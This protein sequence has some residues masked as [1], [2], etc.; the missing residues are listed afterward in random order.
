MRQK[1]LFEVEV[2]D[3]VVESDMQLV[4]GGAALFDRLGKLVLEPRE[5]FGVGAQ[6]GDDFQRRQ[7]MHGADPPRLGANDRRESVA[8]LLAKVG[9]SLGT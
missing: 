1:G 7:Q 9:C 4:G 5:P 8:K 3:E 6:R 2:L